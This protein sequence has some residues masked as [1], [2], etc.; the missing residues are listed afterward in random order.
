MTETLQQR[1]RLIVSPQDTLSLPLIMLVTSWLMMVFGVFGSI[2]P[3]NAVV[4]V[5][6]VLCAFSIA[7]AVYLILD[8]DRPLS[9]LI[10]ISSAPLRDALSHID[11]P[12]IDEGH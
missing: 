12:P 8:L 6:I 1:W 4:Y 2:S 10:R 3:R 9:G 7:S 11:A 5:T